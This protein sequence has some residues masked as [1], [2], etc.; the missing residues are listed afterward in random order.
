MVRRD[1]KWPDW[2]VV[3]TLWNSHKIPDVEIMPYKLGTIQQP[4]VMREE[5]SENRVS[6]MVSNPQ[7]STASHLCRTLFDAPLELMAAYKLNAYCVEKE[8]FEFRR[9]ILVSAFERYGES[10]GGW[11]NANA[12]Y[13]LP[14][15]DELNLYLH[16]KDERVGWQETV[17]EAATCWRRIA[18]QWVIVR[19]PRLMD[20]RSEEYRKYQAY[21]DR[22]CEN[23]EREE[24][25][26]LR[27][28]F[29]RS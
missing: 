4:W 9:M 14:Y 16:S 27:R 22:A 19:V 12:K 23:R 3:F 1:L 29:E 13:V 10:I 15:V 11:W 5:Y 6:C 18:E 26:R 17:E 25:E 8:Y 7:A 2:Q 28:K 20:H 21:S 24:Y